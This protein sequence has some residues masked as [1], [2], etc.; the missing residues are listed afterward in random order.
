MTK[1]YCKQADS[2]IVR[3]SHI[4]SAKPREILLEG[5]LARSGRALIAR[6][7]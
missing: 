1:E 7:P 2:C 5:L 6:D 3:M 4:S